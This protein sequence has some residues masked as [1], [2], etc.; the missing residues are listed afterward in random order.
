MSK[1][2]IGIATC[3]RP[4]MLKKALLSLEGQT[5]KA[6]IT[7]L[8]ADNDAEGRAGILAA[9]QLAQDGYRF[10]VAAFVVEERGI[11][12]V[13]NALVESAFVQGSADVLV[14]MDDDQ[15]AEP[16]WLQALISMQ[17]ATDADVVGSAVLPEFEGP[18][19][20]WAQDC[21]V[22]CRRS[23]SHG[24]VGVVYGTGGTLLS[25]NVMKTMSIPFF[26]VA[27][28]LSGGEDAEFFKRLM[29]EGG[30]FARAADAI[31]Y[32]VY[33]TARVNLRW[34]MRRSFRT[35]VSDTRINLLHQ[36]RARVLSREAVLIPAAFLATPFKLLLAIG[37]AGRQ[38]DA[39]CKAARACGKIAGLA[40]SRYREYAVIHGH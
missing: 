23:D 5:I 12:Q 9:S 30:R 17:A 4:E 6:D 1:I 22:F 11:S 36:G 2:M 33:P 25:R 8:V 29:A 34:A 37:R 18:V 19:P 10:P 16:G 15:W 26:N 35:G 28:S 32:E 31:I 39:L 38:V 27:F 20:T 3:K 24:R 14:F 13:R 40:G 21:Q 7:V